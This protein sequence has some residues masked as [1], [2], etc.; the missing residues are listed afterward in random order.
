MAKK[1][2]IYSY[3][4]IALFLSVV[5]ML[6]GFS[7]LAWADAVS[8][9]VNT[10]QGSDD[11]TGIF[12]PTEPRLPPAIEE[13]PEETTTDC[14]YI[15]GYGDRQSRGWREGN[16]QATG[17]ECNPR[18]API[19][20]QRR[21]ENWAECQT[22]CESLGAGC[23]TAMR[24]AHMGVVEREL[25][26][27]PHIVNI[28][29]PIYNDHYCIAYGRDFPQARPNNNHCPIGSERLFIHFGQGACQP[30]REVSHGRV[31]SSAINPS[32]TRCQTSQN[33][34][35]GNAPPSL[36]CAARLCR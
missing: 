28:R 21:V 12:V 34:P 19:I 3:L 27:P 14:S 30:T 5:I 2:N 4:Y 35:S 26:D 33:I 31:I 6:V 16:H 22:W 20:G 18:L 13:E 24:Q 1:H 11:S 8:N 29:Q 7:K 17:D 25:G 15:D 36:Q 10:I 23:C 32:R 9:P